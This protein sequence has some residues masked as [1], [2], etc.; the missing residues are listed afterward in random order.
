M[1]RWSGGA[2]G[3][4]MIL[5]SL[6]LGW[7][8][9]FAPFALAQSTAEVR[10]TEG[11]IRGFLTV[12]EMNGTVIGNGELTQIPRGERVTS[13]LVLRFKDGSTYDETVH[14]SQKNRFQLLNYRLVQKGPVFKLPLDMRIDRSTG[15]AIVRYT[16]EDGK[17]QVESERLELPPDLMNGMLPILLKNIR[18]GTRQTIVSLVA[19]TP[20]PRLVKL[21]ISPEGEAKFLAGGASRKATQYRIK[22]DIGGILGVLAPLV[23]KQPEDSHAWVLDGEAPA[24]V[25]LEGPLFMDGPIWRIETASPVWQGR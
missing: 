1:N 12:R 18:P 7:A 24:F 3:A 6:L 8:I 13:H 17:Q 15:R 23:G 25:R 2:L 19:P 9:L 16:D 14:F 4:G 22:V 21:E 11:L 20:K 10:F 5:R